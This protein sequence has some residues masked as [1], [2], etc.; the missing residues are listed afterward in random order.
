MQR[1]L[2]ASAA[3][4]TLLLGVLAWS[5]FLRAAPPPAAAAAPAGEPA[6]ANHGAPAP[7]HGAAPAAPTGPA[8]SGSSHGTEPHAGPATGHEEAPAPGHAA[9]AAPVAPARPAAKP[10]PRLPVLRS[11]DPTIATTP[12]VPAEELPQP[13]QQRAPA[14]AHDAAH[15]TAATPAP[16]AAGSRRAAPQRPAAI[17]PP[18]AS[19][20]PALPPG[21]PQPGAL[22]GTVRDGAG[23]PVAGVSVLA[24]SSAAD[25]ASEATTDQAGAYR[26]G[27]LKP[28]RYLVFTDL[29]GKLAGH[30]PARAVEVI[31]GGEGRLELREASAGAAVRVRVLQ[32]DGSAATAQATLVVGLVPDPAMLAGLLGTQAVVMPEPAT[33]ALLRRVAAGVYTVVLFQGAATPP[34]VVARP[35][36]VRGEGEQELLVR[37]PDDL[38]AGDSPPA[39]ATGAASSRPARPRRAAPARA[40]H[41]RAPSRGARRSAAPAR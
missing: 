23:A 19:G 2:I 10:P 22:A 4:L 6:A 18:A 29:R 31:P 30:V 17:P 26:L 41:R 35:L 15:G 16:A 33:P 28:G 25:D 13:P 27:P 32:A 1:A 9:A 12:Y 39:P 3:V 24:V 7:E 20:A 40:A 37:L 8:P 5:R 14:T 34:L 21:P 11:P 36:T 38:K